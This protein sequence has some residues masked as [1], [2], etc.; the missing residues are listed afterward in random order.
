MIQNVP[1]VRI[2]LPYNLYIAVE[3]CFFCWPLFCG[4][5][6]VQLEVASYYELIVSIILI[7]TT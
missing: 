3:M 5:C 7:V 6:Q 4:S 2:L 1:Y